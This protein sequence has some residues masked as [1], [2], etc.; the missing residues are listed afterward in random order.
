M[1]SS[2]EHLDERQFLL[3]VRRLADTLATGADASPYVGSGVDYAHTRLYTAGDSTRNIDWRVTARTGKTF[4]KEYEAHKRMTVHLVVDASPSMRL[5]TASR[6]KFDWAVML[7]GALG[8]SALNRQNP[9]GFYSTAETNPHAQVRPTL[10]R[11]HVHRWLAAMRIDDG[12]GPHTS[13]ATVVNR[14]DA[15]CTERGVVVIMSDL[16]EPSAVAAIKHL[17]QRQDVV[18]LRLADAAETRPVGRGIFRA[19]E[20]ETGRRFL[21]LGR[22]VAAS[23]ADAKSRLNAAEVDVIELCVNDAFLP[24][25]QLFLRDRSRKKSR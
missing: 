7:G 20:A 23:F 10:S 13:I 15:S 24:R 5:G 11:D 22:R 21:G 19:A 17:A 9:T 12:H 4:V 8:L 2:H 16:H 14:L 6:T 3:A 18:V 25:L 1:P